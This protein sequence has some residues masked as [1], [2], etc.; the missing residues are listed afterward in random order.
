M[1]SSHPVAYY[2]CMKEYLTS[3]RQM[4]TRDWLFDAGIAAAALAFG[5]LQLLLNS[6]TIIIAD[7]GFRQMMGVVNTS[8]PTIAYVAM[9]ITTLPLILR[10]LYSW[11][12]L[13][14]TL[15]SFFFF[16]DLFRGYAFAVIGPAVALFTIAH[17]R[18]RNETILASVIAIVALLFVVVP[19]SNASLALFLRIQNMMYMAV[20]ALAGYALRMHQE[21]VVEAE[22]RALEAEKAT[23]EEAARRVEEER[24]RIA[25]EV[26]DINAH[27]L[28]AI[29]IQAAAAE[30]IVETDPEAAKHAIATVRTTSKV[31]LDEIRA[32]IGVLRQEPGQESMAPTSGTERMEDLVRYLTEAGLEVEFQQSEYEKDRVPSYIDIALFGIARESITNI[33]RHAQATQVSITL[34]TGPAKAYLSIDDNGIG[35]SYGAEATGHGIQGMSERVGVLGGVLTTRNRAQGGFSVQVEIPLDSKGEA[36]E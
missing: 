13:I 30:R 22:Q 36:H 5:C 32:M 19:A 23:E 24:V 28:S 4:Q 15:L 14:F 2:G 17:E 6:S 3:D 9:A 20:A 27:S 31:A 33:I 8:P 34:R 26:H 16:Q 10:R 18:S 7:E 29:S 35:I 11:P 25:R 1:A 12:V 21:Y